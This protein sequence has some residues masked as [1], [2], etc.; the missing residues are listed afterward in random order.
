M[1]NRLVYLINTSTYRHRPATDNVSWPE[2][3]SG[4]KNVINCLVV[5]LEGPTPRRRGGGQGYVGI[6]AYRAFGAL[7]KK[8]NAKLGTKGNMYLERKKKPQ[9]ITNLKK[10]DKCHKQHKI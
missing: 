5:E 10:A 2:Y 1:H 6:E 4:P 9:Q 7:F 8:E 3:F